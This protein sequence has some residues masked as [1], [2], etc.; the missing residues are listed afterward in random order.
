MR[1]LIAADME[2]IS[3]V[4]HWDHVDSNHK[5]Y[6]RFRKL[7]T[8]DVNAAIRG[9]FD[10]G[11]EEVIVADGHGRGRNILIEEIDPRARLN[12]GSPS[13]FAMVQGVDSGVN[14][15][16]FVGYHARV[17]SQNAI[18]DHT[19]SSSSVANVWLNGQVVGEIGWN[20]AV[21]GHY[22]VPVILIS[23]DQTACA[24]AAALLGPIETAVVKHAR[25]R[26]AAECLPPET[27]HQMIY[28]AAKRAITR[29]R[30]GQAPQPLRLQLPVT[31]TVELI[32]SDMADRAAIVPGARRLEGK[33]VELTAD[34]V[35]TAYRS[36]RTAVTVALG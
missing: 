34:D 28:E 31:V 20:A 9:A 17:G 26:M 18:L 19:W 4:V 10:G 27:S 15:A 32:T 11:C 6:A 3:G 7:M 12:S 30:A 5:E 21:C 35:A 36:F 13:P 25:G 14:A 23:G 29:L 22:E 16:M 1:V 33:R 8:G 2:G 24:E